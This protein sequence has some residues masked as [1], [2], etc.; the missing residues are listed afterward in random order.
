M[1]LYFSEYYRHIFIKIKFNYSI[2][3]IS[4]FGNI[5]LFLLG[6]IYNLLLFVIYKFNVLIF[7]NN[8]F[9]WKN[10]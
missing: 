8:Y 5:N 2:S 3:F 9:I 10:N 7:I 1:L 6:V 4:F